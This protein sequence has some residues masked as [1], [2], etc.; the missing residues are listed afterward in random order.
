MLPRKSVSSDAVSRIKLSVCTMVLTN[1]SVAAFAGF[2]LLVSYFTNASA[3][4]MYTLC[5]FSR[6]QSLRI[7]NDPRVSSNCRSLANRSKIAFRTCWNCASSVTL[8]TPR[9]SLCASEMRDRTCRLESTTSSLG[10]DSVRSR[11]GSS[12]ARCSFMSAFRFSSSMLIHPSAAIFVG[13]SSL[14]SNSPMSV[15]NNG[16]SSN[17]PLVSF[18]ILRKSALVPS[19]TSRISISPSDMHHKMAP[20]ICDMN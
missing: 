3:S 12:S 17:A 18:T 14:F 20:S 8:A 13:T 19:A 11:T 7:I 15:S 16:R 5:A 10:S 6:T 4:R 2:P 1:S 9:R